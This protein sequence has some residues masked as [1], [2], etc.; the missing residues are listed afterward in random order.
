MKVVGRESRV[1][2]NLGRQGREQLRQTRRHQR[3]GCRNRYRSRCRVR[4]RKRSGES[5]S[6]NNLAAR[7]MHYKAG[8]L[9]QVGQMVLLLGGPRRRNPEQGKY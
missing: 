8:E 5:I 6:Q 4:L 9:S 7:N 3:R 2:K 1:R